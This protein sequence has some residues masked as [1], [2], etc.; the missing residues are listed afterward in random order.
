MIRKQL[1]IQVVVGAAIVNYNVIMLIEIIKNEKVLL[2]MM[3]LMMIMIMIMIV[4]NIVHQLAVQ[5]YQRK[6]LILFLLLLNLPGVL[7]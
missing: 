6:A 1:V 7:Q 5:H 2:M 4:I 3:V